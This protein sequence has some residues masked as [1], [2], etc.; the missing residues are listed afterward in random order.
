MRDYQKY[1]TTVAVF[2]AVLYAALLVASFGMI[3]LFT[4]LE[5]IND[6]DVGSLVGPVMT[7]A[8]VLLVFTT[9]LFLG[10]RTPPEQQRIVIGYAIGSGFAAIAAFVVTGALLHTGEEGVL[11]NLLSL[12]ADVLRGP[13]AWT[14]GILAFI[15]TV[16]YSWL[17]AAR[18]TERG[19]PL[20][21][22]ERRGE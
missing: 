7:V 11:F 13:F 20:W 1:A 5:V 10:V 22:W 19:R 8:A 12:P 9:M 16:A 17:L 6:P 15:V 18:F 2:A 3:S 21:P 14:V 4:D